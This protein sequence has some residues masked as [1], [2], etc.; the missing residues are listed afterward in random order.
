MSPVLRHLLTLQD[1]LLPTFVALCV[2][3]HLRERRVPLLLILN[4]NFPFGDVERIRSVESVDL[5]LE[6]HEFGGVEGVLEHLRREQDESI[7]EV[8]VCA[9][10]GD[11]LGLELDEGLALFHLVLSD[12]LVLEDDPRIGIGHQLSL[13]L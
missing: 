9:L 6:L 13:L 11:D 7:I 8:S 3:I 12:G 10:V 4:M 2:D 1:S 5:F